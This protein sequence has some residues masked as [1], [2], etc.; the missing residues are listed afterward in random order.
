MVVAH[1]R[2]YDT[3]RELDKIKADED[4]HSSAN[5]GLIHNVIPTEPFDK[6][7]KP[8]TE[9]ANLMDRMHNHFFPQ[10]VSY[11][12]LDQN[13]DGV[14]ERGEMKNYLEHRLDWLGV[15]YYT[16]SVVRGRKSI[17]ARLFAGI[18]VIPEMV[19][20][21]GFACKPNSTSVDGMPTSDFGWEVYPE[22]MLQ[23]LKAMQRYECP[24]FITEN[25]VADARD[26]LR[27]KFISDHLGVLDRAINEQKIDIR[28]YFHW[29]LTDNYEWAEGFKMKFGL[30]EVD[31][32]SK[33]R[34]QR[35]SAKIY[36][37]AVKG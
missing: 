37:A 12:W 11:G 31:P 3:I 16:R 19:Q 8:Y 6:A 10:S 4:S 15:N 34:M 24:L 25:G 18:P 30:Y 5:I 13:L 20:N 27:P 32:E 9:A 28:G 29:S 7:S 26:V 33:R 21:Y 35:K 36:M 17:M 14:K 23:A 22:G 2:A 1:A